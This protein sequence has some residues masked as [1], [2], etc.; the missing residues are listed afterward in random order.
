V[1]DWRLGPDQWLEKQGKYDF[2][3]TGNFAR[4]KALVESM[5]KKHN[6][7]RVIFNSISEGGSYTKI[8]LQNVDQAWKD[9]YVAGWQSMGGVYAGAVE[10]ALNMITGDYMYQ[11][12]LPWLN[13][14][15]FRDATQAY[16]GLAVLAPAITGDKKLDAKKMI[17]TPKRS[18]TYGE[19]RQALIDA[20]RHISRQVYDHTFPKL[21]NISEHPGV[22]MWCLYGTG[23]KTVNGIK[24]KESGHKMA[25]EDKPEIVY[26]D[27]DGTV[28]LDSLAICKNWAKNSHR[29]STNDK[30]NSALTRNDVTFDPI[31][32]LEEDLTDEEE[33][34]RRSL[35]TATV[36]NYHTVSHV[37]MLADMDSILDMT[38]FTAQAIYSPKEKDKL[39]ATL[40]AFEAEKSYHQ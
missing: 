35:L 20:G 26:G 9:K 23:V 16:P 6:N 32:H 25:E 7:K 33:A 18:Y 27:G 30:A 38:G 31:R 3:E 24:Y 4:M 15:Q 19:Y 14:K 11:S 28:H 21:V 1:Y 29:P 13:M 17:H 5:Y 36:H 10:I 12:M 8:F 37:G 2:I 34:D 40:Q 22:R 39:K